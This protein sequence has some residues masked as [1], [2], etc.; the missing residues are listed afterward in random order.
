MADATVWAFDPGE[1]KQAAHLVCQSVDIH[2]QECATHSVTVADGLASPAA[3]RAIAVYLMC[4]GVLRAVNTDLTIA[5][6][7]LGIQAARPGLVTSQVEHLVGRDNSVTQQ[8]RED[9]RDPWVAEGLAHMLLWSSGQYAAFGPPGVLS[10]LAPMHTDVKE[11][12]LDLVGLHAEG[13]LLA[14]TV[15]EAKT[16]ADRISARVGEAAHLF[17]QIQER[18]PDRVLQVREKVF[19]LSSALAAPL[20]AKVPGTLWLDRRAYLPFAAYGAASRF[21]PVHPRPAFR[22][23]GVTASR[24]RL[25]CI[26]L[27]DYRA[28]FDAIA[29]WMRHEARRIEGTA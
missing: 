5:T 17:L 29:D 1:I 23:V 19:L 4:A 22:R 21:S 14:L 3:V 25:I 18:E 6:N 20:Q 12:G 16:S 8:F 28:F 24:I 7:V 9:W 13:D 10:A 15:G 11:H 27:A 26:P 2:C